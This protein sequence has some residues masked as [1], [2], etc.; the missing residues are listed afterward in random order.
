MFFGS[1]DDVQ[2][3]ENDPL[4]ED[5]EAM[6][7]RDGAQSHRL[8]GEAAKAQQVVMSSLNSNVKASI[9]TKKNL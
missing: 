4:Y 2:Q 8:T 5:D 6:T 7:Y 9:A 3:Q 1:I